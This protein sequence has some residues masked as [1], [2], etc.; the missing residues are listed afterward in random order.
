MTV[1]RKIQ[2]LTETR[3]P[4][5]VEGGE[6]LES[7]TVSAYWRGRWGRDNEP[8]AESKTRVETELRY[9]VAHKGDGESYKTVKA[10]KCL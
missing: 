5:H 9:R 10:T 6:G 8:M 4:C 1:R 7:E 3:R 2:R